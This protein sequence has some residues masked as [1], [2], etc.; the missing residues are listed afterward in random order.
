MEWVFFLKKGEHKT[1]IVH[2]SDFVY[3]LKNDN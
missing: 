3:K 2:K 1:M